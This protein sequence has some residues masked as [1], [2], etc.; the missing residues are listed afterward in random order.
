MSENNSLQTSGNW[1][2]GD[3]P[4]IIKFVTI[5]HKIII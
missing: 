3:A 5:I 2:I 4:K 1:E